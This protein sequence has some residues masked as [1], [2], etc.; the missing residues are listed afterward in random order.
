MRKPSVYGLWLG[1]ALVATPLMANGGPNDNITGVVILPQN[2]VILGKDFTVSVQGVQQAKNKWPCGVQVLL[3]NNWT[4][5][6]KLTTFPANFVF[7]GDFTPYSPNVKLTLGTYNVVAQ[8]RDRN[9]QSNEACSGEARTSVT[10]HVEPPKY[11]VAP[12]SPPN[13]RDRVYPPPK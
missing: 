2:P 3:G 1:F 11:N 9:G 6:V 5:S 10:V 13:P 8:G 7:P 12:P 4:S